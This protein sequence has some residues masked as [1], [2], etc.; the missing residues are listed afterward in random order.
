MFEYRTV[1][2][3]CAA[4][5]LVSGG[6]W[7]QAMASQALDFNRD[8]R[9]ILSD[10]CYACHGPDAQKRKAGLR[11]DQEQAAKADLG[12]YAAI[13]AGNIADSV[14]IERVLSEDEDEVM[15]PPEF[16]KPLTPDQI[17]VLKRWVS[18]GAKWDN[19]WSFEPI[20]RPVPPTIED[21]RWTRNAVDRFVLARLTEEELDPQ[22]EASR[23]VLIR[24]VTFD[25]TG[26]PPTPDEV[27]QFLIDES[28]DAYERVVDRLLRS[29]RYGEH[30]ARFWLDA[31]RY[32][33]CLLYT[34]PSPRD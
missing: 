17:E 12:G 24:R 5:L 4:L 19:H 1:R 2:H 9:P 21:D 30:M 10:H 33:D 29:S 13:V 26:L 8:V 18:D 11:F 34:S 28:P 23:D 32:G 25:L 16:K 20:V 14:L 7:S 27:D 3:F 31:A 15:P 6:V 22:P